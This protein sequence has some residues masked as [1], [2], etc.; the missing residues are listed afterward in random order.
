[1]V[2]ILLVPAADLQQL[3]GTELGS[4]P[5]GRRVDL[6]SLAWQLG[7]LKVPLRM[8]FAF[9][10]TGTEICALQCAEGSTISNVVCLG[11]RGVGEP[12]ALWLLKAF[13]FVPLA[14][15]WGL[16]GELHFVFL[17]AEIS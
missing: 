9:A 5:C 1:M 4:L 2:L 10:A 17:G 13:G 11:T 16:P 8:C 12:L 14:V 7:W 6:S 15:Q 3:L